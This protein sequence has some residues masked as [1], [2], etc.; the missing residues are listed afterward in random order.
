MSPKFVPFELET[1]AEPWENRGAQ[2][3]ESGVHPL[4][5]QELL[6]LAGASPSR[7]SMSARLRAVERTDSA[8]A[9]CAPLPAPRRQILVTTGSSEANFLTCWRLIEPGDKVAVMIR[10]TCRPPG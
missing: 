10:I 8:R 4:S 6:G 3:L 2:S 9:H 1:V 7:C 5:I